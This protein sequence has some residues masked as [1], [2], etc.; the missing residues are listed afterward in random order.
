MLSGIVRKWCNLLILPFSCLGGY[1]LP[2]ENLSK[3]HSIRSNHHV[4]RAI[5]YNGV[6][7]LLS[8]NGCEKSIALDQLIWFTF[9]QVGKKWFFSRNVNGFNRMMPRRSFDFVFLFHCSCVC[10]RSHVQPENWKYGSCKFDR[11]FSF[12]GT[13]KNAT[14]EQMSIHNIRTHARTYGHCSF[15]SQ[16]P[17]A[18]IFRDALKWDI[19]T[20][21]SIKEVSKA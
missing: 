8:K 17:F 16:I 15:V 6:V 19:I 7:V 14:H 11:F 21:H 10:I 18:L 1:A 12:I 13:Q 4:S 2:V 20:F 5:V 9:I 3:K